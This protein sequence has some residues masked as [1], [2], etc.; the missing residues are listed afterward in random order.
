MEKKNIRKSSGKTRRFG[1]KRVFQFIKDRNGELMK[2][3]KE[4]KVGGEHFSMI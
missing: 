1:E 3:K 4:V 2:G